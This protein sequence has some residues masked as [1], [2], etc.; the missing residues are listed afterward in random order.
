MYRALKTILLVG[1]ILVA[2]GLISYIGFI[3]YTAKKA[4]YYSRQENE[5]SIT[6]GG[7]CR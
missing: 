2:A 7:S 1:G 3:L 6:A 5:D 4:S